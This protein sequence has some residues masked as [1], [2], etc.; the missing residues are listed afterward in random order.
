MKDRSLIL[1]NNNMQCNYLLMKT[2]HS[3]KDDYDIHKLCNKKCHLFHS[4]NSNKE[5]Y[6]NTDAE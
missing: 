3:C 1:I 6:C 5:S 2:M 4:M